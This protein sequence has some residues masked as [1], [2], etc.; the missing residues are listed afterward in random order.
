[1]GRWGGVCR[2]TNVPARKGLLRVRR[3]DFG[4]V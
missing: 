1:M 3:S 2:A 4:L